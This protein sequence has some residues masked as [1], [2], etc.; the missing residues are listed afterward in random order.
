MADPLLPSPGSKRAKRR[1][2]ME[3][4]FEHGFAQSAK[5]RKALARVL[6]AQEKRKKD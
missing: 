5:A 3:G 2:R 4:H 6:R 1:K